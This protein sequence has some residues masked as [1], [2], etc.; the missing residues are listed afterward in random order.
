MKITAGTPATIVPVSQLLGNVFAQDPA[1]AEYVSQSRQ[2]Q[3]TLQRMFTVLLEEF[4]VSE[5]HVDTVWDGEELLGAALWAEPGNDLKLR[6]HLRLIPRLV[7]TLGF[8]FP[9][10]ALLNFHDAGAAPKFAHWYLF[11]IA[12]SPASRGRGVGGALLDHGIT[13]AGDEAIYLE[14]T[15]SRSQALYERKGFVPMGRIPS[16]GPVREV[17]MWKP[18]CLT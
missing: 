4:F 10:A 8:S 12:A 1:L 7:K 16:P 5:G 9:R 11:V 6:H 2:P 15:S 18:P 13:R 3:Q 14:S 17:G